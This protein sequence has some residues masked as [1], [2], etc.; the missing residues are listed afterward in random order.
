MVYLINFQSSNRVLT[1][2]V[3]KFKVFLLFSRFELFPPE[4][5]LLLSGPELPEGFGPVPSLRVA[6][7]LK[8]VP[9]PVRMYCL[10]L[11]VPVSTVRTLFSFSFMAIQVFDRRTLTI[12]GLSL[13]SYRSSTL[14]V[15]LT[16]S[17]ASN[18][19]SSAWRSWRVKGRSWINLIG[20]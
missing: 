8:V 9:S 6:P 13:P 12:S 15:H 19:K 2:S 3:P 11:G 4:F 14:T 20:S 5:L 1:L 7:A 18:L 16:P 17:V 10:T